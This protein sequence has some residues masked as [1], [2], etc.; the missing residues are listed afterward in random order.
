MALSREV[1]VERRPREQWAD[2]L[3]VLV[4]AGVVVL[5]AAT[6][7]LTPIAG[8]YYEERTTS[9]VW[10][11]LLSGPALLGATF[12]L[13]PLFLLAGWFSARSLARRGPGGFAGSR[14]LRLGVPLVVY[15]VLI[16][17]LTAYLGGGWRTVPLGTRPME[18]SVLWFVAALL[19]FS[20][21]YAAL[22]RLRPAPA[23]RRPLRAGVLAAAVAA[24]AVTSFA[25]W[26]LWPANEVMF[27]NLRLGSWPQGAVL[28]ALG[29]L[30]AEAGW[31]DA[32]PSALARRLG[33]VAAAGVAGL[34][35][36]MVSLVVTRGADQ[37][38]VMGADLPTMA[39]ALLDGLI[40]VSGTLWFIAWLRGRW[41]SH[42]PLLGKAARASYAT[43]VAHPL[44]LTAVMVAMAAVPLAPEIKFLLVAPAAVAACFAAGYALT[45]VPGLSKV[46]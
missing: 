20:L 14:L 41:P 31:L 34:V 8:W 44:V 5:H 27:L 23:P 36:L 12:A 9:T 3:R 37:A 35:T 21:A 17:P 2:N 11:V 39:F 32:L 38:L 4:I 24:I 13:G 29:V 25:L 26:Q 16:D 45:R 42:G 7:Y 33:W 22:R 1:I 30:G 10:L 43:Y 40:A 19:V 18:V 15:V 6:A 28:F 46:L